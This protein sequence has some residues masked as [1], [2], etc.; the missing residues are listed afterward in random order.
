[1]VKILPDFL[2]VGPPRC[3]TKNL[4][5]YLDQHPEICMAYYNK[6]LHYFDRNY[7]KDLSW[8]EKKFDKCDE[9]KVIGEKT[10]TYITKEKYAERIYDILPKAKLIFIFREPVSRCY[11]DYWQS[12]KTGKE[13]L[14][15][16][17]VVMKKDNKY[18]HRSK[19]FTLLQ[20]F[21]IFSEKQK[22]ILISE[23]FWNDPIDTAK[24]V[25]DFLEVDSSFTPK[26]EKKVKKGK[27]PRSR[28]LAKLAYNEY[29]LPILTG[30]SNLESKVRDIINAINLKSDYP[31]MKE[32]MKIELK[33]YYKDEI[34]KLEDYMGKDLS[35]WY[36]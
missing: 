10:A 23:E 7:E 21:E 29:N 22:L 33:D 1:M 8:Y 34:Q 35:I 6:E 16:D 13:E 9:E 11:S 15:F 5:S 25:Y 28:F 18:L 36:E 20:N 24:K 19:Y 3:G 14:S 27:A 17:E 31:Q 4:S 12:V 32:D 26:K 2:I 30:R